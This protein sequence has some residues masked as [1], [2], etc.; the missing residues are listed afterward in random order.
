MDLSI[1]GAG[2]L[3]ALAKDLKAAGDKSLRKDLLSGL[4]TVGKA[5]LVPLS[6][7]AALE[8]LPSSG[9]LNEYVAASTFSVRTR[10]SVGN[11]G[12]R[13]VG[14]KKGHD[15]KA[16][17]GGKVRHPV[18]GNRSVWALQS[19][20]AGWWTEGMSDSTVLTPVRKE[21]LQ[22][23]DDVARRLARG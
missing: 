18:F 23:M 20:D 10:T 17:D 11:P 8:G 6:K 12:V 7:K 5:H 21:L 19:I 4:R 9:G 15:I 22:V 14:S 16:M 2:D 1:R 3:A 13:L